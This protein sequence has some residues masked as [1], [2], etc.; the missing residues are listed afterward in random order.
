MQVA[1]A[2]DRTVS[3][4]EQALVSIRQ[5]ILSGEYP[6]GSRL[7]LHVLAQ[8][9]GASLIP[10]REALRVLEA[11]RLIETIPNRGARVVPLSVEDMND[12]Y[13]VRITLESEAVRMATPIDGATH[14]ELLDILDGIAVAVSKGDTDEV[15]RLNR[16]F[17][18]GIYRKSQSTW[19]LYLI[20]LLWNHTERYQRLSLESRH[21]AADGEHREILEALADGRAEH[22]AKAMRNHL[23]TTAKLVADS[24]S[25]RFE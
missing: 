10:V 22:A 16:E 11:E 21:D 13:S 14:K 2:G 12:L 7:R 5:R 20:D 23:A 3:L 25:A 19:F 6:P 1:A 18:Y 9:T 15:I 24:F 4:V 8:E 17:H